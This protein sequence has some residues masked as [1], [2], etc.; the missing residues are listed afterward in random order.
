MSAILISALFAACGAFAAASLTSDLRRAVAAARALC[1]ALRA[2][3]VPQELRYR[4]EECE[5]R[6]AG[7]T[8]LRPAFPV[9]PARPRSGPSLRAA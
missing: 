8:I 5:V 2:A 1:A 9:R 3:D 4:I 7:A 6:Q